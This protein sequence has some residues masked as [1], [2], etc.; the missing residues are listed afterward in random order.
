MRPRTPL[1]QSCLGRFCPKMI[2]PNLAARVYLGFLAAEDY[3][4]QEP[5]YQVARWYDLLW[6]LIPVAGICGFLLAIQG[7]WQSIDGMGDVGDRLMS[8]LK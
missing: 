2:E 4:E 6:F 5:A 8:D 3:P 1:R 7:R